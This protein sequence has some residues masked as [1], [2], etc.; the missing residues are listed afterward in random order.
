[1]SGPVPL[2]P[3]CLHGVDRGKKLYLLLFRLHLGFAS[4]LFLLVSPPKSCMDVSF[5][6]YV[7]RASPT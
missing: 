2:L 5:P 3:I 6:Q 7:P 4:G 1:M